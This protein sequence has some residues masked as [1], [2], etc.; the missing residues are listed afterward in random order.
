[1]L[2]LLFLSSLTGIYGTTE[3]QADLAY[4]RG[5]GLIFKRLRDNRCCRPASAA[6]DDLARVPDRVDA[7]EASGDVRTFARDGGRLEQCRE[8]SRD[9]R[10]GEAHRRQRASHAEPL[11]P[12][13]VV[14]LVE[15]HRHD[16]LWPAGGERLSRGAYAAVVYERGGTRQ[17]RTERGVVRAPYSLGQRVGEVLGEAGQQNAAP[18]QPPAGVASRREEPA[19]LTVP[20]ARSEDDRRAACGPRLLQK[21]VGSGGTPVAPRSS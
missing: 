15:R 7:I 10:T 17:N 20:G 5:D 4:S 2:P 21:R 9:G 16:Q 18:P 14:G 11:Q 19:S 1:M 3:Q 8:L 6:F 12:S 13:R